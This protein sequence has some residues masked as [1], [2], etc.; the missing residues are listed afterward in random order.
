MFIKQQRENPSLIISYSGD[1]VGFYFAFDYFIKF[2]QFL[3][4]YF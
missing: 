2:Q 4:Y 3:E 1:Y